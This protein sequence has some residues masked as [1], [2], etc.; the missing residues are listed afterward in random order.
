MRYLYGKSRPK[1]T[2][3]LYKNCCT[4]KP[5]LAHIMLCCSLQAVDPNLPRDVTN[6]P[7]LQLAALH[8]QM[9]SVQLLLEADAQV[10]KAD[11]E[12]KS[13]FRGSIFWRPAKLDWR[14][15]A[16]YWH[17]RGSHGNKKLLGASA[18]L[19]VTGA[20]LVVTRSY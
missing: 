3:L 2:Q 4:H 5:F 6:A 17:F 9:T 7:A 13:P 20:L 1:Q 12:G 10:D 19:V 11:H 16:S 15:K 8:G 14:K 18:S